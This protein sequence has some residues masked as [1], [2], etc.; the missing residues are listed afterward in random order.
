MPLVYVSQSHVQTL[1][2]CFSLM[3]TLCCRRVPSPPRA[4]PLKGSTTTATEDATCHY[5]ADDGDH[6]AAFP[7]LWQ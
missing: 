2:S 3:S 5:S 6:F 7:R 1:P 4:T